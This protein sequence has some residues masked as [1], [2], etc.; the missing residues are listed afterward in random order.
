MSAS[1][2]IIYSKKQNTTT[3]FSTNSSIQPTK[4]YSH[5]A[6]IQCH[7]EKP[8]SARGAFL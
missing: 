3:I 5:K 6:N 4:N 7:H 2:E 1:I 8:Y